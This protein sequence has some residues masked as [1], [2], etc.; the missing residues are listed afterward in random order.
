MRVNTNGIGRAMPHCKGP[1]LVT[2]YGV[3]IAFCFGAFVGLSSAVEDEAGAGDKGAAPRYDADIKPILAKNCF[4]C[5]GRWFPR[6]GL[7]L[8]S[9]ASLRKGGK[10]G[11]AIAPGFPEKSLLVTLIRAEQEARNKMPPGGP[12]L[13]PAEIQRIAEWVRRG[14]L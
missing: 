10:S 1:G 6:R 8:N 7:R 5:H 14:A 4:Q 11:P 9:A 12:R 13:S 2:A 3:L